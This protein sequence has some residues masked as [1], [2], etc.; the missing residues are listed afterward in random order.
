MVPT[1][2][3]RLKTLFALMGVVIILIGATI[4]LSE[5]VWA[6]VWPPDM[7]AEPF[8]RAMAGLVVA[9]VGGQI[10]WVALRRPPE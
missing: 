7:L 8:Y 6:L 4:A 5:R 10:V 2:D 3:R 1:P 9:S